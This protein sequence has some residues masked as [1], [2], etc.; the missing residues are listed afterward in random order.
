MLFLVSGEAGAD[1]FVVHIWQRL[2]RESCGQGFIYCTVYQMNDPN[3]L[4]PGMMGY[5]HLT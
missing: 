4:L 1:P 3:L 5:N 2:G